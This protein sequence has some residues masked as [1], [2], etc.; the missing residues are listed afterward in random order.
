MSATKQSTSAGRE[1]QHAHKG[2]RSNRQHRI[3]PGWIKKGGAAVGFLSTCIA[4]VIGGQNLIR[5]SEN[6]IKDSGG[7]NTS[8]QTDDRLKLV[9][10]D[11]DEFL[12]QLGLT[13]INEGS[14]PDTISRPH[15]S[16]Q[17]DQD[18]I[19]YSDQDVSFDKDG[20]VLDFFP[21]ILQKDESLQL[22]CS[23]KWKP[24]GNYPRA[25]SKKP[26]ADVGQPLTGLIELKDLGDARKS[27]KR[28]FGLLAADILQDLKPE[29][30]KAIYCL[31]IDDGQSLISEGVV[32]G[33]AQ[34]SLLGFRINPVGIRPGPMMPLASIGIW[35]VAVPAASSH[36]AAKG[37]IASGREVPSGKANQLGVNIR[38]C[39][40]EE[41]L[42]I[43]KAPYKK[44]VMG[45]LP[46]GVVMIQVEQR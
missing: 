22:I 10:A 26:D 28:Q 7:P 27:I 45:K 29:A 30:P 23:I 21:L 4:L 20:K 25:G 14:K 1:R 8:V 18:V 17:S 38:P 41:E 35:P 31:N 12:F 5:S 34:L 46:C 24:A 40:G 9:K 16:L 43:F 13:L 19:T 15:A 36:D 3:S 37:E 33:G 11:G 6:M 44:T 2:S 39:G 32:T 42:I